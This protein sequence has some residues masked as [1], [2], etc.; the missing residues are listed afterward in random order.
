MLTQWWLGLLLASNVRV[1][2][3]ISQ[4]LVVWGPS[5]WLLAQL[6]AIHSKACVPYHT[7]VGVRQQLVVQRHFLRSSDGS[8]APSCQHSLIR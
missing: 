1:A 6:A 4:F 2:A 8:K 5:R 7:L 3:A